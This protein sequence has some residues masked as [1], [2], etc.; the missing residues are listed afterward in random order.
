MISCAVYT[1]PMDKNWRQQPGWSKS[2]VTDWSYR[3]VDKYVIHYY[4]LLLVGSHIKRIHLCIFLIK[5]SR[6][7]ITIFLSTAVHLPYMYIGITIV[8]L[9]GWRYQTIILFSHS[10]YIWC[11]A[12]Y[13]FW[14]FICISIPFA[15]LYGGEKIQFLVFDISICRSY[16][17]VWAHP[18]VSYQIRK[19]ADCACAENAGNVF[20]TTDFK[21]N[22]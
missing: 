8:Q 10:C 13:Y 2:F 4:M 21:W 1:I 17:Y 5:C 16:P 9:S 6:K 18:W 3:P 22:R 20:P 12:G 14:I 15:V 11:I 7:T 19:N